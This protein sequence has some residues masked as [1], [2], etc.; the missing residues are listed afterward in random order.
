MALTCSRWVLVVFNILFFVFGLALLGIGIYSHVESTAVDDYLRVIDRS[1]NIFKNFGSICIVVGVFCTGLGFTGLFGAI[2]DHRGCLIFFVILVIIVFV[3]ELVAGGLAYGFHNKIED[4]VRS[5]MQST[6]LE[7][8]GESS[9]SKSWDSIQRN[10]Q[11]CGVFNATDWDANNNNYTTA[12]N[13]TFPAS[14]VCQTEAGCNE[15]TPSTPW[16]MTFSTGCFTQV[17]ERIL[18]NWKAWGGA[19]I[20]FAVIEIIGIVFG[21]IAIRGVNKGYQMSY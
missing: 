13:S 15:N 8:D 17:D 14:C 12:F 5:G 18:K 9:L 11:C 7:Y 2:K 1:D 3:L 19:A 20:A 10:Q 6:I 4:S 21:F 16:N